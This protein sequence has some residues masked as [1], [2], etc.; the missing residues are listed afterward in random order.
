[1]T[2]GLNMT[3]ANT[4]PILIFKLYIKAAH[5][6]FMDSVYLGRAHSYVL[7]P[8]GHHG[9]TS[10]SRRRLALPLQAFVHVR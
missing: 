4:P 10:A 8:P 7:I 3:L 2:L 6:V 9:P 1:M 5:A